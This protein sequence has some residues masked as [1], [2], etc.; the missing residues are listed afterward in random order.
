MN[1]DF[2]PEMLDEALA[3]IVINAQEARDAFLLGKDRE[4][5]AAS[6]A[7]LSAFAAATHQL[8]LKPKEP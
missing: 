4:G 5:R 3:A 1:A 6:Y 8:S 7:A 2:D